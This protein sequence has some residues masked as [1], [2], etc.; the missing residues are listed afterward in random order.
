MSRP[1]LSA[2]QAILAS[3]AIAV[4]GVSANPRKFGAV[5]YRELKSRGRKVVPVHPTRTTVDGDPC[6]PSVA[7]LPPGITSV[8]SVVPPAATEKVV[9]E[10]AARGIASIWMQQGSSSPAAVRKATEAGMTVV[11]GQC[12]LMFLE[13]LGT[14]HRAHRF[15]ARLFGH[16]PR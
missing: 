2:V 4:V 5:L 16:Y 7:A 14:P 8:V 6:Y 3:P 9:D 10:C 1:P 11:H 12:L 13:P 15:F